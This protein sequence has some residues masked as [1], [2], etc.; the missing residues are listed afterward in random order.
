MNDK[1]TEKSFTVGVCT[2]FNNIKTSNPANPAAKSG[3]LFRQPQLYR[4][5][6]S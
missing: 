4:E 2:L 6:R 3:I 1:N 5:P